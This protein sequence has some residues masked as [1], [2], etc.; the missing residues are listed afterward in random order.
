MGILVMEPQETVKPRKM[1]A[2]SKDSSIAR[3]DVR[4][5]HRW[6]LHNYSLAANCFL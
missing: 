1:K 3:T 4:S 5:R 6:E 2:I